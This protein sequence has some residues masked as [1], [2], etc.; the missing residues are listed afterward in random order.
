M[1]GVRG[2]AIMD[3]VH[4]YTHSR[5]QHLGGVMPEFWSVW[6]QSWRKEDLWI[7]PAPKRQAR[8]NWRMYMQGIQS[9][10]QGKVQMQPTLQKARLHVHTVCVPPCA[11]QASSATCSLLGAQRGRICE[12][13]LQP[14]R[15]AL[16]SRIAGTAV[17]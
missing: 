17:M 8:W 15:T 13:V 9:C 10:M 11:W 4:T 7:W 6:K 5:K 2:C 12:M 3:T 16:C 1:A 14:L